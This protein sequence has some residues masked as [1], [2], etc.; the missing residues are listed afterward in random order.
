MDEFIG[1]STPSNQNMIVEVHGRIPWVARHLRIRSTHL[2]EIV[3]KEFR[4]S[5]PFPV[6]DDY[7]RG[8]SLW[9][10]LH[11]NFRAIDECRIERSIKY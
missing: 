2:L 3:V 6:N 5:I 10:R 7:H 8:Q 4:I 9:V 11:W 1:V